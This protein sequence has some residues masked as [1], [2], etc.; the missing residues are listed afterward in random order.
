MSSDTDK[1]APHMNQP[2][3]NSPLKYFPTVR[4]NLP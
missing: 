3:S 2:Q 1:G 4:N